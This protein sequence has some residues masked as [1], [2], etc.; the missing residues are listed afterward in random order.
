MLS[1]VSFN[2]AVL[3]ICG[4][5][6][7]N[8][9][10]AINGY[11]QINTTHKMRSE[12]AI[13]TENNEKRV[14]L[15]SN[16]LSSDIT[17]QTDNFTLTSIINL[18]S[19]FSDGMQAIFQDKTYSA[20]NTTTNLANHSEL[21][22]RE[23]YIEIPLDQYFLTLG[24]QQVVWGKADGIKILDVVNPQS[25][26]EFIFD[27]FEQSRIPLWMLNVEFSFENNDVLQLLWIPDTTVHRLAPQNA[28]F[29][30]TTSRIVP[31]LADTPFSPTGDINVIQNPNNRPSTHVKNAD[32]GLRWT[33][34]INGWD[35]SLNYLY[36]F[37][38]LPLFNTSYSPQRLNINAEY[39]RSHLLGGSFATTFKEIT[40]RSEMAYQTHIKQRNL[41]NQISQYNE[42]T[43]LLG[44]DYFGFNNTLVSAQFM[45]NHAINTQ[46]N[47][48]KPTTDT[49]VTFLIRNAFWHDTLTSELLV[50]KNIDD[51]DGFINA[52]LIHDY[53][54]N[55]KIWLTTDIIWGKAEGL[56]GQFKQ[57][58][59]IKFGFEISF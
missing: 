48:T 51:Q 40:L 47:L 19:Q 24:K 2:R 52:S 21:T 9:F 25:F 57:K 1:A 56:Y 7:T 38:D 4:L 23:L 15:F 30:V 43:Y 37:V 32:I 39:F 17:Y 11:A 49:H 26:N 59:R 8:L 12:I 22:L 34:F 16:S 5:S 14:Q 45:Q 31:Q 13:A 3:F 42:L 10:C 55:L 54:D 28:S 35:L 53:N 36:H 50:V 33:R 18:N 58:D 27:E 46:P 29:T 6:A 20:F 41:H 44:I